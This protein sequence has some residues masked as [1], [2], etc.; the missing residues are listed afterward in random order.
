M[1]LAQM[2]GPLLVAIVLLAAA[3]FVLLVLLACAMN[4]R[5]L[6]ISELREVIEEKKTPEVT[7]ENSLA[8]LSEEEIEKVREVGR[9]KIEAWEREHFRSLL[10]TPILGFWYEHTEYVPANSTQN[11]RDSTETLP[12]VK[13]DS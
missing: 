2:I 1:E 7:F 4:R 3:V 9:K 12:S 10:T 8:D 13:H 6:N 11:P 5:Q